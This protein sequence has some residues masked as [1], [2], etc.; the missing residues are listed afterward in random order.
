MFN[1]DHVKGVLLDHDTRVDVVV[2]ETLECVNE[3]LK[4]NGINVSI[5]NYTM[6]SSSDQYTIILSLDNLNVQER[7]QAWTSE[8]GI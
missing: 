3:L 7:K 5:K 1:R 4:R 8:F 6:D 2:D